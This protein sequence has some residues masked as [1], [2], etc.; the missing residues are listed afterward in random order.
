MPYTPS[1]INDAAN[2][3]AANNPVPNNNNDIDWQSLMHP[4]DR[5]AIDAMEKLPGFSTLMK[6]ILTGVF[7]KSMY[8]EKI[9]QNL[10]LGPNQLPEYY[11]LLVD[12]CN[13]LKIKEIPDFYLE[14][15][16]M[17][18]ACTFGEKRVFIT[19][20]SGLLELLS[21]D[22][23][24]TVLAHE[25]GHILFKHVRYSMVAQCIRRGLNTAVGN[26][27]TLATFGLTEGFEQIVYRWERM[28]EYS[29]DRVSAIFAG[30]A[31]RASQV[32]MGLAGGPKDI[33]KN[34]NYEEY[35]NQIRDHEAVFGQTGMEGLISKSTLLNMDHPF[36]ASRALEMQ[37]F[38]K[39][40]RF[41][42]IVRQLGTYCCPKCGGRISPNSNSNICANGHF[43]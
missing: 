21:P 13:T 27:A 17:P 20:T 18:N 7:E 23:V 4:D 30:S 39:E 26:V 43:N 15:N 19:M 29:S 2:N 32:I 41:K 42:N 3:D 5:A 35:C 10:R 16:P 34:V 11:N 40:Q 22:D 1:F 14:M 24:K 25:C 28:S 33:I 6:W 8:A 36:N 37:K 38:S 31:K 12:V 9:S